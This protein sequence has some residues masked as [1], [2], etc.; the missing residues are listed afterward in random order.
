LRIT[1]L[2]IAAYPLPLL[3]GAMKLKLLQ[4]RC[5]PR[6]ENRTCNPNVLSTVLAISA[7]LFSSGRAASFSQCHRMSVVI[8]SLRSSSLL[9]STPPAIWMSVTDSMRGAFR[10]SKV[11]NK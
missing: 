6:C 2:S 1:L 5:T 8:I 3:P 10:I 11:V 9:S 4:V 7:I